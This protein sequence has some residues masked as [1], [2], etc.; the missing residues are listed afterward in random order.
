MAIQQETGKSLRFIGR[1]IAQEIWKYFE[2]K[3]NPETIRKKAE[4]L[5]GTN[6]PPETTNSNHSEIE[7]N[8]T[9]KDK[10]KDG[11]YRGGVR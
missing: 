8:Q 4:R 6:V 10:S 11:T 1:Q 7:E 2:T 9:T 5:S 3:V